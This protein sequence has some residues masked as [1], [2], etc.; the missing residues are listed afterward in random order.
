MPANTA[1][2][3]TLVDD[4]LLTFGARPY[5]RLWKQPVGKARALHSQR[6]I[7]FGVP[8]MA[9]LGGILACGRRLEVEVKTGTGRLSPDQAR[10]RAT[11]ERF[12]GVYTLARSCDDLEETLRSHLSECPVCSAPPPPPP[13][14]Q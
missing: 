14:T 3:Q 2:H 9:D 5:V 10:W 8:G 7:S 1:A 11:I 13:A 4:L 12:R 6:V